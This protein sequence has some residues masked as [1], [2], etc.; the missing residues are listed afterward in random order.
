L[1]FSF[2]PD[3]VELASGRLV[4]A[5]FAGVLFLFSIREAAKDDDLE[6][7]CIRPDQNWIVPVIDWK[8]IDL[9]R[10]WRHLVAGLSRYRKR[11]AGENT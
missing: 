6:R 10:H 2:Q 7:F 8:D 1:Q 11:A 5:A 4:R 9:L 3:S